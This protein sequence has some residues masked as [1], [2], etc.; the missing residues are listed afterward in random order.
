MGLYNSNAPDW[1]G[2]ASIG[3]ACVGLIYLLT[4]LLMSCQSYSARRAATKEKE[5][6]DLQQAI[7]MAHALGPQAWQGPQA[8][9]TSSPQLYSGQKP[10]SVAYAGYGQRT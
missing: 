5:A 2:P 3:V 8:G 1:A 6:R 4:S 7:A 9:W 10:S